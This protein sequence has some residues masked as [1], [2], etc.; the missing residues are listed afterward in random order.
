MYYFL[1]GYTA[2]LA[3]TERGVTEPQ[4][5]FSTCFGAPF[6][7]HFPWVYADM[8]GERLNKHKCN[9]WLVNTGWSGGSYG[10]GQRM[11]IAHTR[12]MV[13]SSLDG[14][15]AGVPTVADPVFGL[16]VP[17]HCPGVPSDVLM[18]RNTWVDKDAYDAKA[19]DLARKF[20]E[21]FK[22]FVGKTSADVVAAGPQV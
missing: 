4:A 15:L 2:K 10:V 22:Q 7:V 8:L 14:S 6:M 3:G 16:C 12:S 21:N 19:H 20:V 9:V 11:S 13:T 1:S 18:P 5:T 17:E